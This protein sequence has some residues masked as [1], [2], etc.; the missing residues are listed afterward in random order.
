MIFAV[1]TIGSVLLYDTQHP[2]PFAKFTGLHLAP[3]NDA[4]WAVTG[5]AGGNARNIVL[6]FCSSDGY[7][8]FVRFEDG[9]LGIK[10]SWII[11]LTQNY[12]SL[13]IQERL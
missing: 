13:F 3:I 10:A 9:A 7:L 4:A 11:L 12:F 6:T 8:T 1:V 5:G 2:F